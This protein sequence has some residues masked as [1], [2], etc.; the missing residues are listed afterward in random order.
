MAAVV[1]FTAEAVVSTEAD[2]VEASTAAVVAFMA[3]VFVAGTSGAL[4]EDS[5]VFTTAL[6]A[7][8]SGVFEAIASSL[9]GPPGSTDLISALL[10]TGTDI[11]T[12]IAMVHG[13]DPTHTPP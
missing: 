9:A 13:G 4:A 7:E 8:A 12:P 3:A 6:V 5:V 2:S 1:V 10:P 11:R